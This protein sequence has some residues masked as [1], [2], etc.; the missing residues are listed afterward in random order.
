MGIQHIYFLFHCEC[1][2]ACL[3]GGRRGRRGRQGSVFVWCEH[4]EKQFNVWNM[5]RTN[6]SMCIG[7]ALW[8]VHFVES[9][10]RNCTNHTHQILASAVVWCHP[11][12][13]ITV[14]FRCHLYLLLWV[15]VWIVISRPPN[16]HWCGKTSFFCPSG[17]CVKFI[18]SFICFYT[19]T[20]HNKQL[21]TEYTLMKHE[22]QLWINFRSNLLYALVPQIQIVLFSHSRS[23][24]DVYVKMH[25]DTQS[26]C[27][28]YYCYVISIEYS[29]Y[30]I[31]ICFAF[32]WDTDKK[33]P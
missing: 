28:N 23:I 19:Q 13:S 20:K 3:C 30:K 6:L 22:F 29:V 1:V 8:F 2:C 4:G 9:T 17:S 7:S 14:L 33:T 32:G 18:S 12:H 5:V 21:Y 27:S 24:F 11:T 31:S 15:Y 16:E 25:R 26:I 10:K